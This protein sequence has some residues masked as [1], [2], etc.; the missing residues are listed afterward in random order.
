MTGLRRVACL[1]G[2]AAALVLSASGCTDYTYFNVHITI[3]PAIDDNNSI[4]RREINSCLVYV[5]AGDKQI[6]EHKP[7]AQLNGNPACSP[8]KTPLDVGT[9]DYSTARTSGTLR[10]I[11]NML[12]LNGIVTVQG[13]AQA[14]LRVGQVLSVDLV[15]EPCQT[16]CQQDTIPKTCPVNTCSFR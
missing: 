2:S 3:D 11:V 10:F 13:S 5:F 14:D 15:A 8:Q 9:M 1:I 4:T 6:E 12:D 16:D 7:L